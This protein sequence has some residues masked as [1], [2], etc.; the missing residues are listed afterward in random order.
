M[1][2]ANPEAVGVQLRTLGIVP[3]KV[4]QKPKDISE[5]LPFLQ[6]GVKT[7]DLVIFTRQFAT[8]IDAGLLHEVR[9]LLEMG[10]GPELR[11]MKAIGYRHIVPVAEGSDIL[12]NAVVEMQRDTLRFA[13]RQRTW[14]RGVPATPSLRR[15]SSFAVPRRRTRGPVDTRGPPQGPKKH[16]DAH[17]NS[18]PYLST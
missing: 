9:G 3:T 14:L 15:K 13:R 5:Y 8:M 10:Y 6:P 4:K 12:A 7:R 18:T 17:S 2:A 16:H 1:E 11:P